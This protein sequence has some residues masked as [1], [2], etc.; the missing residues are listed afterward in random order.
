LGKRDTFQLFRKKLKN[1]FHKNDIVKV[2]LILLGKIILHGINNYPPYKLKT[3]PFHVGGYDHRP[4]PGRAESWDT[5]HPKTLSGV[6]TVQ[7]VVNPQLSYTT[8]LL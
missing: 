2:D 7:Q 5:R 1:Y 8:H 6:T 3:P 4:Q